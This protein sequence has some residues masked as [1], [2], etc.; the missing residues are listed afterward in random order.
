MSESTMTDKEVT[1]KELEQMLW[2]LW[3]EV[4]DECLPRPNELKQPVL[5]PD[6]DSGEI[7]HSVISKEPS[8]DEHTFHVLEQYSDNPR[9]LLKG[10]LSHNVKHYMRFPR[11][12][13]VAIVLKHMAHTFFEWGGN[14]ERKKEFGEMVFTHYTDLVT[15]LSAYFNSPAADSILE[16]YRAMGQAVE[17]DLER[18]PELLKH[19]KPTLLDLDFYGYQ[20]SQTAD[21]EI[22]LITLPEE[23][24]EIAEK[25]RKIPFLTKSGYVFEHSGTLDLESF[26]HHVGSMRAYGRLLQELEEDEEEDKYSG[27]GEG[28]G[29]EGKGEGEGKGKSEEQGGGGSFQ[30]KKGDGDPGEAEPQIGGT[31]SDFGHNHPS[32]PSDS[33]STDDM[34]KGLDTIRDTF[35]KHYYEMLR[36]FAKEEWPEAFEQE[37]G[38]KIKTGDGQ[39]IGRGGDQT[40]LDWKE[41]DIKYYRRLKKIP[42]YILPKRLRSPSGGSIPMMRK[43]YEI[44]DPLNKID[45]FKSHGML[46]PG[47]TPMK[48]KVEHMTYDWQPQVPHAYIYMDSS[49]SMPD[50]RK[51]KSEHVKA[52]VTIARNHL[53]NDSLVG[54]VNFSSQSYPI[55]LG[56]DLDLIIW[57]LVGTQRGGTDIDL[58]KFDEILP[59]EERGQFTDSRGRLDREKS[60]E[61][62]EWM[63]SQDARTRK[64]IRGAIT[65]HL[66]IEHDNLVEATLDALDIYFITD[67]G[68]ANLKELY[69]KFDSMAHK[70]RITILHCPP[71]F[72]MKLDD[73]PP[74]VTYHRIESEK[75]LMK[76]TVGVLKKNVWEYEG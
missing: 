37:A 63:S 32:S 52:G 75:D 8:I 58:L 65:K 5:T 53:I 76:V 74:N 31:C 43:P 72:D 73:L 39:G 60:E 24:E 36:D 13:A 69:K 4:L 3:P 51:H 49:G 59:P 70:C 57:A 30:S 28:D 16:L 68:I 22:T 46:L 14:E 9:E 55:P 29:Q 34:K 7:M 38:N 67:G 56:T 10:M 35:T 62:L 45:I 64:M 47:I 25:M 50:P 19:Y 61:M 41:D 23:L 42:V 54:I 2:E 6:D 20:F 27:G 21:Q 40:L 11:H 26:L 71:T 66:T 44:G 33:M 12:P 17:D 1:R 15:N 18:H 48:V